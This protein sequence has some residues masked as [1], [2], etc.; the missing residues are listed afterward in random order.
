VE[1]DG[2][3]TFDDFADAWEEN[4]AE[5]PK[6]TYSSKG[7]ERFRRLSR[8]CSKFLPIHNVRGRLRY[9][10]AFCVVFLEF[11]RNEA[12]R[13]NDSNFEK[14]ITKVT[15]DRQTFDDTFK[16]RV[17]TRPPLV[18]SLL[19]HYV[20]TGKTQG[21]SQ[22]IPEPEPKIA[23]KSYKGGQ[24]I[25]TVHSTPRVSEPT[26]DDQDSDEVDEI[27]PFDPALVKDQLEPLLRM[28]ATFPDPAAIFTDTGLPRYVWLPEYLC[29]AVLPKSVLLNHKTSEHLFSLPQDYD[30][31]QAALEDVIG[32]TQ[33]SESQ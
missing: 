14:C 9:H 17:G 24:F 6:A 23:I 30:D 11:L 33:D 29:L 7:R 1:I 31:L 15:N 21:A 18:L 10:E 3:W 4:Q 28:L 16:T 5:L 25:P 8:K 12:K 22:W 32:E 27:I 19:K 13:V 20:D 2:L 26:M